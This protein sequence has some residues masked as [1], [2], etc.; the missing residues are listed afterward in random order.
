VTAEQVG[1]RPSELRKLRQPSAFVQ[2]KQVV[3]QPA[4]PPCRESAPRVA[5]L[6]EDARDPI[7]PVLR[8]TGV[9]LLDCQALGQVVR[10]DGRR[11]QGVRLG[12]SGEAPSPGGDVIVCKP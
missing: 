12:R 10:I 9:P 7:G 8:Q 4:P 3:D 1:R 11:S 6:V 2:R 5:D